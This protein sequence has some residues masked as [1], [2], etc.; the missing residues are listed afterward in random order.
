[1]TI[2]TVNVYGADGGLY[3]LLEDGED[4]SGAVAFPVDRCYTEDL[5]KEARGLRVVMVRHLPRSAEV[6]G[7][8]RVNGTRLVSQITGYVTDPKLHRAWLWAT[9]DLDLSTV[10]WKAKP[11]P[12][13][14]SFVGIPDL[15][16]IWREAQPASIVRVDLPDEGIC[17][18]CGAHGSAF[19]SHMEDTL[20]GAKAWIAETKK[21]RT[22]VEVIE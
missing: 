2:K 5:P 15:G 21:N 6:N 20:P 9:F 8:P 1:M 10:R 7:A 4:E 22:T 12:A 19:P 13:A 18:L 14:W 11:K 16:R 3:R 17:Y